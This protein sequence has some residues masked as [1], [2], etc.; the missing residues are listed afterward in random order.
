[1]S[2]RTHKKSKN[3][4]A[5]CK[6]R[7]IRC[8]ETLPVCVNCRTTER[9]CSFLELGRTI[10]EPI[11]VYPSPAVTTTLP[12]TESP[13]DHVGTV[14]QTD[15]QYC[16]NVDHTDLFCHFFT[17]TSQTFQTE[18]ESGLLGISIVRQYLHLAPY[19]L[20][21]ILAIAALHLSLLE[22]A[23]QDHYR[24]Y[25]SGLQTQALSLFNNA[26]TTTNESH[27]VPS[28]IFSSLI[29][30]HV[31]C[32]TL[33]YREDD[34]NVF[35]DRFTAFFRL[36]Q[37][38]RI[39][40]SGSW[41]ALRRHN[42]LKTWL[43]TLERVAEVANAG[44]EC[45]QLREMVGSADIG[46]QSQE[47]YRLAIKHLQ[48]AFDVDR[49]AQTRPESKQMLFAWTILVPSGYIDLLM[50]RRPEALV[51]LAFYG[52]ILHRY[53]DLWVVGDGGAFLIRSITTSLGSYWERWLAWPNAM[54]E[55]LS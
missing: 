47:A 2:R 39:L 22:A 35:L 17:Q 16:V 7:H 51:V 14:L 25:A 3:G 29:G 5:N 43:H 37:G 44:T 26:A 50:Q 24:N 6:R 45:E 49:C 46:P 31:L 18:S 9:A 1:M 38:V 27:Q 15:Q 52:V 53:S 23:R 21:E 8:D 33:R 30:V 34:L 42:D 41:A 36:H 13:G 11:Q 32:D 55:A 19:L 4:C 12:G 10:S 20:H 48:W 40:A 28:L 54:I